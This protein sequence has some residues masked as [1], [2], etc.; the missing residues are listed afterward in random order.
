[1]VG[2]WAGFDGCRNANAFWQ[3]ALEF[4][5]GCVKAKLMKSIRSLFI[6][7][8]GIVRPDALGAASYAPSLQ[9]FNAT[10]TQP[11]K[12]IQSCGQVHANRQ[13]HTES[14]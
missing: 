13:S 10:A 6:N 14:I 7:D 11:I 5:E 2:I 12:Q 1:M 4:V 9:S 3:A 8:D